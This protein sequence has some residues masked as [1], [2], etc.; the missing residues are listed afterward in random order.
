MKEKIRV[1]VFLSFSFIL[2]AGCEKLKLNLPKAAVATPPKAEIKG[3]VIA[4]VN[5]NPITLEDLNVEVDTF[6]AYVPAD[7]PNEKIDTRDKK[8]NYLK[9]ELV[10]K[11]LLV[12]AAKDRGLERN[13]EVQK[14]L[15]NFKENLIVAELVREETANADVTSSEIEDYYNRSKEQLKEPEER[16]LR[17]IAVGT[18]GEA[19]AVMIELLQGGDFAAIARQKS[20]AESA[21]K[22]GD[23]GFIKKGI[24]SPQFDD[25]AFSPSLEVGAV[26]NYFKGPGGYYILK[27]EAKREGKVKSL[28]EL[29]DDIKNGLTFLKRQQKIEDLISKLSRDAKIEIYEGQ[30]K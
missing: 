17:E 18:E 6:N 13:E 3:T 11:A 23:L 9:N 5:G 7:K 16:Q 28:S 26:S 15:E 14:A 30:I 12:Q 24:K 1:A 19:K 10:R 4:K 21:Q 2:L 8:I 25:V 29:W 22:G 27:L 20:T